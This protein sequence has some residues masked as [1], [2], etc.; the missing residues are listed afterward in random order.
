[1]LT[2][3]RVLVTARRRAE[4][5]A[6]ALE[7]R[8]AAVDRV[9]LLTSVPTDRA[10]LLRRTTEVLA[11]PP[12]LVVVLSG[13][14]L[15]EWVRVVESEGLLDGLLSALGPARLA[16]RG[17]QA[18]AA[19]RR[20]GLVPDPV[21]EAE[22]VAELREFLLAD[23]VDGSRVLLQHHGVPDHALEGAFRAAGAA[24]IPLEAYRCGPPPDPGAVARSS[25]G[26]ATGEYDA[27]TFTSAPAARAWVD[28]LRAE[29][30]LDR[31]RGRVDA[32]ELLLAALGS[33]TAEPLGFAGLLARQPS[34]PRLGA[35]ARLLVDELGHGR[36]VLRT[37]EGSLRVRAEVATLDH[38]P[39]AVPPSSL[40]V[41]RRLAATPGRV[42]SRDA[43]LA[44]LPG[45][46]EDPHRVEV[47]VARLR[48]SLRACGVDGRLVRTVVKRGYLL[49]GRA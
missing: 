31:V 45:G 11:H 30:V 29:G 25:R 23:G 38:R 32:G 5:L 34:R 2:G 9:P 18:A 4:E 10:E 7:V 36:H 46:S 49:A 44:A 21:A 39:L 16:A 19:V 15:R 6:A 20:L 41:L 17:P 14:G 24:V 22:T 43:L 27:V 13:A 1:M 33:V 26:L 48:E 3:C 8:G 47:A 40:A 35:L 28:G 37:P 12:D 42:V